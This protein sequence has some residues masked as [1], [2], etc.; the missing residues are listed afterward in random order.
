VKLG[1]ASVLNPIAVAAKLGS[2]QL[3]VE[4]VMN[5]VET[6]SD[7]KPFEWSAEIFQHAGEVGL[8]GDNRVELVEGQVFEMSPMGTPH[9]IALML[10]FG[11]MSRV[12]GDRYP[13]LIQGPLALS[14]KS[15]PF[16]DA[17]ILKGQPRDY[18]GGLP[19]GALLVIEIS[20]STLSFDRGVKARM[21]SAAGIEEYWILNLVDHTME[22][23]R[24]PISGGYGEKMVANKGDLLSPLAA[25]E[26]VF[27][28]GNLIP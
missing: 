18:A 8:F 21:Y 12:V 14:D 15:Q 1:F 13:V 19:A 5:A 20:E 2:R 23:F 11:E 6:I 7:P 16:P 26:L 9:A 28:A 4:T 10:L 17:A 22:V 27:E 24:K 25:P 3:A